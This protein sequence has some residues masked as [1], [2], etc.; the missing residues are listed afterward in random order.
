MIHRSKRYRHKFTKEQLHRLEQFFDQRMCLNSSKRLQ[1][2]DELNLTDVQ[3]RMWFQNRRVRMKKKFKKMANEQQHLQGASFGPPCSRSVIR[4]QPNQVRP[5]TVSYLTLHQP[6]HLPNTSSLYMA[7][8]HTRRP[9]RYHPHQSRIYVPIR[10][11]P[12]PRCPENHQY[13]HACYRPGNGKQLSSM[14]QEHP[15][16]ERLTNS[17]TEIQSLEESK[18]KVKKEVVDLTDDEHCHTLENSPLLAPLNDRLA[19]LQNYVLSG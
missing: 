18:I 9:Y 15:S 7:D 6:R 10:Y 11:N 2:A 3:L 17:N 19:G 5:D 1:L 12:Y 8:Q 13:D 14:V 16:S 4:M